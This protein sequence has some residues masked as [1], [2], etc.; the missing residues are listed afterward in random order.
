LKERERREEKEKK[1]KKR[2]EKKR[3]EKKRK[4]KKRKEKK[5]KTHIYFISNNTSTSNKPF[6]LGLSLFMGSALIDARWR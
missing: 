5:R 6:K 2:K 1:E 4:E 3:K